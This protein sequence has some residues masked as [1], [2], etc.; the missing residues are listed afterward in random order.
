MIN[1]SQTKLMVSAAAAS[2]SNYRLNDTKVLLLA[3]LGCE[4]NGLK[5]KDFCRRKLCL[6]TLK[7][8]Q[9]QLNTRGF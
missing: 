3:G 8:I 4:M 9:F 7:T 1:N 6:L 2:D 5:P